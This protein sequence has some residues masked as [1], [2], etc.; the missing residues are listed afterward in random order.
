VPWADFAALLPERVRS[1][2]WMGLASSTGRAPP[3]LCRLRGLPPAA[4]SRIFTVT[5][6]VRLCRR[7]LHR[8]APMFPPP[9]ALR[10]IARRVRAFASLE[11]GFPP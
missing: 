11:A 6:A 3:G 5:P 9:T 7:R 8:V 4:M 1:V 2:R 10:G